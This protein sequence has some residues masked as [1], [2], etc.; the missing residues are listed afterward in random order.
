MRHG[1]ESVFH[2]L[3]RNG[4]QRMRPQQKQLKKLEQFESRPLPESLERAFSEIEKPMVRYADAP[5][6]RAIAPRT[7][8]DIGDMTCP[9][10]DCLVKAGALP[11]DN[12]FEIGRIEAEALD[13][14]PGQEPVEV[15]IEQPENGS[16][17]ALIG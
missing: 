10:M 13:C 11:D 8:R 2:R 4:D 16:R 17:K 12:R 5:E 9:N 3:N 6:S 1:A 14:E 15:E 7:A